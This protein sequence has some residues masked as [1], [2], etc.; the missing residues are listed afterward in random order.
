MHTCI[1][2]VYTVYYVISAVSSSW[3]VCILISDY[4]RNQF[5]T[6]IPCKSLFSSTWRRLI[7]FRSII[8]IFN[9]SSRRLMLD[10]GCIT[11]QKS[12]YSFVWWS[13]SRTDCNH[14][15]WCKCKCIFSLFMCTCVCQKKRKTERK[16]KNFWWLSFTHVC[17]R[18]SVTTR[19]TERT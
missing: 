19:V 17:R 13:D 11:R 5:S 15:Y 10:V 6:R 14:Y 3:L 7:V 4:N 8:I 18:Q 1:E 16:K 12:V 2:H 9:G